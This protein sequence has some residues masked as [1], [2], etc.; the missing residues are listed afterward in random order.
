LKPLIVKATLGLLICQLLAFGSYAGTGSN[1]SDTSKKVSNGLNSEPRKR[2]VVIREPNVVYPEILE[3]HAKHSIDYVAKFSETRRAY[4]QRTYLRS[5]KYFPKANVIL[6]KYNV[7][8][9]FSVLLALESAFNGNAVS[10]A[11]A[12]GYW[13]IMDDVAKEYGLKIANNTKKAAPAVKAKG[14]AKTATA[15]KQVPVDE[16]KNFSKST[17][18]AARY[19]KDRMRNLD[20]NWL[21]IAASYNWG[22]GNVWN[23]M[24]RSGKKNPTFWD[25]KNQVPTETRAYVM[26]FI[27]LNVI[28]KNYEKFRTNTLCFK[29]VTR[30][31]KIEADFAVD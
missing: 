12:V 20:N 19:L 27:A 28:F 17:Y 11:G 21:L 24:Q 18:T 14:A 5:K 23:A 25:I 15:K 30:E 16:R 4:L 7:P 13:Q 2:T 3:E 6:K 8:T 22:V 26:N 9:E 31:E 1:F 29:P 10:G